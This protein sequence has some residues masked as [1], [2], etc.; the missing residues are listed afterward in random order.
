MSTDVTAIKADVE[1]LMPPLVGALKRNQYFDELQGQLRR[2]E[3]IAQA[4]R[5][6]PLIVGIHEAVIILR[7]SDAPDP[8]V[9][10]LLESLIF[11]AGVTEYGHEGDQ[12]DPQEAEITASSGTGSQIVVSKIRRLG[13]R[14]G[15]VPLLKPIV[16]V[17]RTE[18]TPDV[19]HRN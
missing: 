15:A 16:E 17:T 2:T 7:Q 11:Q 13:L 3:K 9:L 18:R 10:E 4:W 12:I 14:I 19:D 1:R 8:H 6:W 5:D